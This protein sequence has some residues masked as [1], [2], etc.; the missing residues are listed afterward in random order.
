MN[1]FYSILFCSIG[2]FSKG[3]SDSGLLRHLQYW[4]QAGWF[5]SN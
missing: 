4:A 1:R 2:L 5:R 3:I